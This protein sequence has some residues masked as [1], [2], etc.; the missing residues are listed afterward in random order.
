MG[1]QC[2]SHGVRTLSVL[3][4]AQLQY[5]SAT[6]PKAVR[7]ARGKLQR[8]EMDAIRLEGHCQARSA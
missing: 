4:N 3:E 8:H 7:E 6:Q 5:A 2:Y 1:P